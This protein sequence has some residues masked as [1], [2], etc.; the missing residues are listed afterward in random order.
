MRTTK[1]ALSCISNRFILLHPLYSDDAGNVISLR[2]RHEMFPESLIVKCEILPLQQEMAQ[3]E[4]VECLSGS[5]FLILVLGVL[6]FSP[7]MIITGV[8]TKNG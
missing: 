3:H 6:L 8:A 1:S 7:A 4:T 2:K 5:S